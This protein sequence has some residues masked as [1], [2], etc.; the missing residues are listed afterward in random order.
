MRC[1]IKNG[2]L[3]KIKDYEV[4]RKSEWLGT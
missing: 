2:I 3:V 1:E 4:G